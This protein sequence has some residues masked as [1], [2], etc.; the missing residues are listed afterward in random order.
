ECP[1][2]WQ[3]TP[4][5]SDHCIKNNVVEIDR[6]TKE[7]VWSYSWYDRFMSYHEVHDADR[8]EN[9][10]TV[11]IDMGQHRT[12]MV[13]E[14]GAVTWEWSAIENLDKGS[15]FWKNHVNGTSRE[16]H[17]YEGPNQDWTH[18]NDVDELENGNLLM[19]IRNFDVLIEV[20][21]ETDDI[22]RVIGEPG[23]RGLMYEQHDPNYLDNHDNVIVADSENDRI[24]EYNTTTME[25]VWRYEGP[26]ADDQ[27]R[28]PRDADRLPN[29][30]TLIVDSRGFRAL[31]VNETGEVVWR[32]DLSD[33]RAIIY[34][35]DR[36]GPDEQLDEEPENVP[37]GDDLNS[38]RHS[39]FSRTIS[40]IEGWLGFILPQ[41][42]GIWGVLAGTVGTASIVGLAIE[43]TRLYR[44]D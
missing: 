24:I 11:I 4:E 26:S 5:G 30:N 27:L 7:V 19:S 3:N 44:R 32:H 9:G 8:L 25:E 13:N 21:P 34:D 28:W 33:R 36:L 29:G 39:A 20:D 23:N 40:S 12:F 18:M 31:E 6:D 1:E 22:V 43:G 37:P 42:V 15:E 17:T 2:K 16:S 14:S 41:W 10:Q 38:T 35:A